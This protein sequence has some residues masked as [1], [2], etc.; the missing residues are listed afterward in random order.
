[1]TSP[2]IS[3]LHQTVLDDKNILNFWEFSFKDHAL[4]NNFV[5]KDYNKYG[6]HGHPNADAHRLFSDFLLDMLK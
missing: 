1:L 5:P 3:S 6:I 4:A 2:F